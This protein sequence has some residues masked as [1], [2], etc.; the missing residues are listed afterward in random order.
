[1]PDVNAP[2]LATPARRWFLALAT[3]A[4]VATY[5]NS[6]SNSFHYD[7][8]HSIVEN[9]HIR[10]LENIPM[11]FWDPGFFSSMTER[12]MYRPLLLVT[13]A[14][15]YQAHGY[16]VFGYHM[17]NV[18]LH[19][20]CTIVVYLL[21]IAIV[22]NAPAAAFGALLFGLHPLQAEAINYISS[23]SESLAA[24]W[25]LLSLLTYLRWRGRLSSDPGRG[26]Y[27]TSLAAFALALLSKATAVVL[28][29]ALLLWEFCRSRREHRPIPWAHNA[30]FWI[31]GLVYLALIQQGIGSALGQPVRELTHQIYTQ[32]KAATYYLQLVAVPA[33]LSVEH[34]FRVS[35]TLW[36]ASVL[37][38]ALLLFSAFLAVQRSLRAA[39][40]LGWTALPLLP[41]SI[42]PLNVLVNEHRLYLPLAS[43][44]IGMALLANPIL[45]R[46]RLT[47]AL[48]VLACLA[49][50]TVT[51]NRI[52]E[53]ELTLWKAAVRQ[54]PEMYR[55]QM[56]LGGAL[57]AS[58]RAEEAVERYRRAVELAPG[59]VEP[60]Y[61][62]ANGLRLLGQIDAAIGSYETSLE[63]DPQFHSSLVNL[64]AVYLDHNQLELSEKLLR[65][66]AE[67]HPSSAEVH[68]RLGVLYVRQGRFD[69][70]GSAYQRAIN[71]RPD[72]AETYYNLA[73]LRWI[74][75]K[76]EEA[77]IR[78][79][80]AIA[81]HPAHL[82]AHMNL[83]SVYLE[84]GGYGL[85]RDIY[86]SGLQ[87]APS[88]PGFHLGL[89]QAFEGLGA[90]EKALKS[91]AR[92][93]RV[94]VG[95]HTREQYVR[96]RIQGLKKR[97]R[98]ET[99]E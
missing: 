56:H 37:F 78:Y 70:A 31:V 74:K 27:L 62:L 63:L 47:A 40:I 52:W 97:A 42:V 77:T 44:A 55:S 11:F 67:H 87:I 99:K 32:L 5:G 26:I 35:E 86:L 80:Q 49:L 10:A 2:L 95:N 20:G 96:T 92:F 21:G 64:S 72:E 14:L 45:G 7:D 71:L 8:F 53:S 30:G 25:Y 65:K 28:P 82:G 75:G 46:R 36:E 85:A 22:G 9:P 91:Y 59:A 15:N 23:R 66:A 69:E 41:A 29:L 61:N 58:G 13:Y 60:H 89:A 38:P 90:P 50:L 79:R 34:G 3:L 6:L 19:T 17:V 76:H 18:A 54:A 1:L 88:E 4:I 93:L 84:D 98:E 48:A 33:H 16:E 57:E 68:R 81:R 83:G 12:A 94:S 39:L 73:N 51:R 43:V 24:F